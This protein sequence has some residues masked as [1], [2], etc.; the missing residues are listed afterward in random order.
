VRVS[1]LVSLL[2]SRWLPSLAAAHKLLFSY[3]HLATSRRRACVDAT[4]RPIPWYTYPAIDYIKQL[5]FRSRTIFEYGSGN[6]TLFWASVASRV[7][8]VEEDETWYHHLAPRLPRNCELVLEVDLDEYVAVVERYKEPFD[9]IVIDGASRGHTRLK[10]AHRALPRL[11]EGGMII[12]DNSD[13]LPESARVLRESGLIEVDMTGFVPISGHTHTTSFFL[14][15]AFAFEP[16]GPRQPMPGPGAADKVWERPVP[17]EKP[18]VQFAGEVFG[19]VSRDQ[20]FTFQ[21]PSGPRSF[22]LIV[23]RASAGRPAAAAI[24]DVD[25]NRILL[26]LQEVTGAAASVEEELATSLT[27]PWDEFCAFVNAHQKRRYALSRDGAPV[28][29]PPRAEG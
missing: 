1:R 15:R 16:V 9:V 20:P 13:W 11:R 17:T 7:V 12:L 4:G 23:C 22:R 26:T 2:S 28:R 24:L 19:A 3:G 18:L 27:L 21:S 6:S 14:H 8:S 5:D 29:R 25:S 10:C